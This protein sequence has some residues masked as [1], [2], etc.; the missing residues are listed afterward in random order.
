MVY[1][2]VGPVH[3]GFCSSGADPSVRN[4]YHASCVACVLT[5]P[6]TPISTG[7]Y[8]VHNAL[9]GGCAVVGRDTGRSST[10]EADVVLRDVLC[11]AVLY[12]SVGGLLVSILA[13]RKISK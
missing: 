4:E 9:S 2:K 10:S 7:S 8:N 13:V 3:A 12:N 1:D 6:P 5:P 11:G